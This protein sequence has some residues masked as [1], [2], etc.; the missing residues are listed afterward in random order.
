MDSSIVRLGQP[1]AQAVY[2]VPAPLSPHGEGESGKASKK[3]GAK[4]KKIVATAAAQ[5]AGGDAN[6]A[7]SQPPTELSTQQLQQF[8]SQ[9]MRA[10]LEAR[11]RRLAEEG[12]DL[13]LGS[14][15]ALPPPP[16]ASNTPSLVEAKR[17]VFRQRMAK[18]LVDEEAADSIAADGALQSARQSALSSSAKETM[19][20]MLDKIDRLLTRWQELA[21]VKRRGRQWNKDEVMT[22]RGE[23]PRGGTVQSP[24]H[25][26]SSGML[27]GIPLPA[28]TPRQFTAGAPVTETTAPTATPRSRQLF[29][30]NPKLLTA[31]GPLAVPAELA[32][33]LSARSA[34]GMPPGTKRALDGFSAPS[35]PLGRSGAAKSF[36]P[37]PLATKLEDKR[38]SFSVDGS[39]D[40]LEREHDQQPR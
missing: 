3:K 7:E 33:Q 29:L 2:N 13:L 8:S 6:E 24:G 30:H 28:N 26:L 4:K 20:Q 36:R 25:I 19:Q 5:N 11:Q 40:D 37:W 16:Q 9:R 23:T 35:S 34:R 15:P 21:P 22:A 38:H 14:A 32:A 27:N 12:Q 17:E 10:R 1:L 18:R 39:V 31:R